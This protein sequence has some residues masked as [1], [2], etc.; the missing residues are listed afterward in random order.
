MSTAQLQTD[1]AR[2]IV[3]DD[4]PVFL[5]VAQEVIDATPGFVAVAL[6]ESADGLAERVQHER[7]QVVLLDVRMPGIDGVAAAR[8][9]GRQPGRP[10][11]VLVSADE[12]PDI[13]AD[14]AAHGADAFV[15]K[16]NFRP[17]VLRA[18]RRRLPAA[19]AGV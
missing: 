13:A 15:P 8:A 14:P 2:V 18:L 10:T 16:E 4:S 7:A 9:L 3:V 1:S 6:L 11:V 17:A 5:A 19:L 12:C